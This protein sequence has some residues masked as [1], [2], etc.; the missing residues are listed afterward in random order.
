MSSP[1]PEGRGI[2]FGCRLGRSL[3][4]P[5]EKKQ[6]CGFTP[7]LSPEKRKLRRF[8]RKRSFDI[9]FE[10]NVRNQY[11]R[12]SRLASSLPFSIERITI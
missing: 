12:I 10:S 8:R 11:F 6:K 3:L 1:L 7:H 2:F 5:S 9:I 4:P